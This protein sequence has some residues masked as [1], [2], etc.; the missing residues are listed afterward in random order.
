M[1]KE[2]DEDACGNGLKVASPTRVV[3]K[4]PEAVKKS[5]KTIRGNQNAYP[6]PDLL[7]TRTKLFLGILETLP[8]QHDNHFAAFLQASAFFCS[9]GMPRLQVVRHGVMTVGQTQCGKTVCAETLKRSLLR[10]HNDPTIDPGSRGP[11][12]EASCVPVVPTDLF[13]PGYT[14]SPCRGVWSRWVFCYS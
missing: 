9:N 12:E 1:N 4:G 6:A 10:L 13:H 3:L 14:P 2:L 5:Q 11:A 7:A 8:A